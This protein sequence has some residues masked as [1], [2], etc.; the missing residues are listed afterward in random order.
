MLQTKNFKEWT[1]VYYDQLFLVL[2]STKM[3]SNKW[4]SYMVQALNIQGSTE[5]FN[6]GS[7]KVQ[8]NLIVLTS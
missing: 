5:V 1:N 6:K 4:V 3:I 8:A 2:S 7:W